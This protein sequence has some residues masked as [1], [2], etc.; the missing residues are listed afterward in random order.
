MVSG[1]ILLSHAMPLKA[2]GSPQSFNLRS[3]SSIARSFSH[4]TLQGLPSHEHLGWML[5]QVAPH[6]ASWISQGQ[7]K[8]LM[9]PKVSLIRWPGLEPASPTVPSLSPAFICSATEGRGHALGSRE[10]PSFLLGLR[11]G[12]KQKHSS[13]HIN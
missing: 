2:K 9:V 13:R 3:H 4:H 12:T 6:L 8:V 5:P 10:G 11:N 7:V 1:Y